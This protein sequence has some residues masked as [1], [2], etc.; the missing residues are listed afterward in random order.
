M[1]NKAD[2]LTNE[3]KTV[4]FAFEEA[5][6]YMCGSDILD[7]DGITAAVELVQLSAYLQLKRKSTLGEHLS[8]IYQEYGYHSNDNSYYICHN[9]VTIKNIFERLS[10]YN[11]TN[12]YPDMIG[13]YKI[14]RV[15]DLFKGYDNGTLNKKPVMLN[16]D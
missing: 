4:L 6:G 1:G 12:S 13:E 2:E 8:F 16:Y 14:I 10:N 9:Q 11:G 15:R 3:G 7:K 5:I